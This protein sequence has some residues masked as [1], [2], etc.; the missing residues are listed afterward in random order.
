M[1]GERGLRRV[2]R[3]KR[4]SYFEVQIMKKKSNAKSKFY[5]KKGATN[6]SKRIAFMGRF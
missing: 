6:A 3:R 2:G 5:A 1:W 4:K